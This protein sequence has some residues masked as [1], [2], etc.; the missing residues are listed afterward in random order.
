MWSSGV[1]LESINNQ[2]PVKFLKEEPDWNEE[3]GKTWQFEFLSESFQWN[4]WKI[5]EIVDS[6]VRL[7]HVYNQSPSRTWDTDCQY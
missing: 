7:E 4:T 5:Q 3:V 2:S 1:H 6:K